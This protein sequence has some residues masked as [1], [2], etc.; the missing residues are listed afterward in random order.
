MKEKT[1]LS[2]MQNRELSWLRFNRRV[3]REALDES[4]PPLER[5]KFISIYTSNLDEFFMIRVG[6]IFDM[7]SVDPSSRDNKTNWKP[8]EELAH[9]YDAVKPMYR[10]RKAIYEKV[11]ADMAGYGVFICSL[12]EL[13]KRD[14]DHAKEYFA[15]ELE[16]LLS[17]QIV[18]ES[19]PF[20]RLQNGLLHIGLLLKNTQ[21]QRT[22]FGV[23]PLP[24]VL[25]A[26]IFLPG[27]NIRAL[28]V[29]DIVFAF[30]KRM[31][32]GYSVAEKCVF[33][34][35]RNADI[36]PVDEAYDFK[37]DFRSRMKELL[38]KRKRLAAVRLETREKISEGFRSYFCEKLSIL[39]QQVYCT[40]SPIHLDFSSALAARLND[41]QRRD[42]LYSRYVPF[43][44]PML[45][46]DEGIM[47]QIE[48][49]DV[50]L[51][52]P[53]E[54][55]EPFLRLVREA[56]YDPNVLSVKITIYRLASRAKLIEYICAA[57]ENGVD[58]SVII[59]LRARFDEQN[60]ID[61][62]EQ[63]EDAGCKVIYGF[64]EYKIH[65]KI[66]LIT[67]RARN[68]ISYITQIGTGNYNEKT[69]EQYT[70]LCLMTADP[71]IGR[72]ANEFFNNLAV[73]NLKGE[74]GLLL[75]APHGL[76]NR[77]LALMDEQIAMGSKGEI[78]FKLNSLT[79]MDVIAKLREASRAGVRIEMI[80]RGICCILPGIPG[81]T[82]NIS[83][84]SIVGRYLEHSRIYRFGHGED[85]KL[86]ISSADFMTR[87]MER[88]VELACPIYDASVR[89]KIHKLI[90]AL[91]SDTQKA[92]RLCSDGS[93]AHL[94]EGDVIGIDSQ[95]TLMRAAER[96]AAETNKKS[97]AKW[98]DS[99]RALIKGRLQ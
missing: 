35:T 14:R 63:L 60:N 30:A 51:S 21:S 76:K 93:Y 80:I 58:V 74:Y 82:E 56:A 50:L 45:N 92:R 70:D 22:V 7:Q 18:D 41:G 29:E 19:H 95:Q 61:W 37:A 78:F 8:E 71:E 85:E 84:R 42:M 23:I 9:I 90:E 57:A 6:S 2:Y 44:T 55:M 10:E 94:C 17:A 64:D 43:Q 52:Y 67:R 12:D 40:R 47:A 33:C 1:D 4:T 15:R 59:E 25:P 98:N 99:L 81:V 72:E 96:E 46:P 79:D 5:L 26:L 83:V 69:A 32:G 16:P 66:C 27:S 36:N 13:S 49:K 53:Y 88:R 34:V 77:I 87:N 62:S 91:F 31:F 28:P 65:S 68:G 38:K 39:K 97:A 24:V 48:R 75:V 20:P 89:E 11:R 73:G 54:S 86:Y 3:L